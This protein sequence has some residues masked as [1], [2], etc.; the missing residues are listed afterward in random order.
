M[1]LNKAL[2]IMD[3]IQ[4]IAKW[5]GNRKEREQDQT[6][7]SLWEF[8]AVVCCIFEHRRMGCSHSPALIQRD[9]GHSARAEVM[10]ICCSH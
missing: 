10:V 8:L 5:K 2:N 1:L 9:M 6:D 3:K 7:F 4:E